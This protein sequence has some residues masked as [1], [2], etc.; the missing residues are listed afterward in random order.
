MDKCKLLFLRLLE[1]FVH[2]SDWDGDT[3]LWTELPLFFLD[4]RFVASSNTRYCTRVE[5]VILVLKN[6]E[7]KK[8]LLF[9]H[10][11]HKRVDIEKDS[12]LDIYIGLENMLIHRGILDIFL[13]RKKEMKILKI[14]GQLFLRPKSLTALS[15]IIKIDF[16]L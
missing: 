4:Y 5:Q 7:I 9:C 15:I 2:K 13:L 11:N 6:A 12:L 10:P 16:F 3:G 8:V 14:T 1:I